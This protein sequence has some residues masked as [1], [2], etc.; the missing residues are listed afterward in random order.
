MYRSNKETTFAFLVGCKKV[1]IL[2]TCMQSSKLKVHIRT[3]N[4]LFVEY[5]KTHEKLANS[6]G[7]P[8]YYRA[9]GET[10]SIFG[11]IQLK[12]SNINVSI[13]IKN[14]KFSSG[15]CIPICI[16]ER[17]IWTPNHF[18]M[19]WENKV[20]TNLVIRLQNLQAYLKPTFLASFGTN[21]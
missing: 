21:A 20:P 6:R 11:A 7:K 13:A 3:R 5:F 18:S 1:I 8:C 10:T 12:M 19:N 2:E 9:I 15:I 17:G 16:Q 4:G 14:T